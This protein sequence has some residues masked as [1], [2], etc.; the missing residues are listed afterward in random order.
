[1]TPDHARDI[2]VHAFTL[3]DALTGDAV[4]ERWS[5][6]LGRETEGTFDS[7]NEA[8]AVAHALA[9]DTGRPVWYQHDG[10]TVRIP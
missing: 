5:V 4:G 7:E 3:V 10:R 1:M 8:L 9:S 6:W 2:V